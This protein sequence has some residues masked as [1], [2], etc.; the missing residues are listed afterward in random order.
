LDDRLEHSHSSNGTPDEI[1]RG[2]RLTETVP[3]KSSDEEPL[4]A[5]VRRV[6][7]F[8]A[9]AAVAIAMLAQYVGSDFVA[10]IAALIAV[11]CLIP[12]LAR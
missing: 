7:F 9:L 3:R 5:E 8:F 1:N 6:F 4:R 11:I 10:A 2:S 12:I